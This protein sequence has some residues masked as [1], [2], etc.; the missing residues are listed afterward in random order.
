[1]DKKGELYLVGFGPGHFNHLTFRAREVIGRADVVVGYRT[2]IDLVADLLEGKEIVATGMTEEIDRAR[3]AVDRAQKG[4]RVAIVS[5]GDVGIYGMAGLIFEILSEIGWKP[6]GDFSVE[7]IPGI[8]AL[9]AVASLV[10]APLTH[11]FAAVSLSDLLTPWAVIEKRLHAAGEG[12]FVIALYNP[13]SKRR[14]WQLKRAQ[15]ILLQYKVPDTP[16]AVVKSAYRE[17]ERIVLTTLDRMA[18][19]EVGMLT[20]ILIGNAS[21]FRYLDFL[22]T[23]RGYSGKYDLE[24]GEILH[25]GIDRPGRSL[26]RPPDFKA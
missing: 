4:E 11:D 22:V 12:D 14:D 26:N 6:G 25:K 24:S 2:Y 23:P 5:S 19:A 10:G 18:E 9:S 20:T 1:M 8:T 3:V 21:T 16:V 15:E 13:Q 17:G 7:V